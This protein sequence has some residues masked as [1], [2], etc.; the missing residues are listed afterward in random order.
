ML[1]ARPICI[2][3]VETTNLGER[4]HEAL[5]VGGHR[6]GQRAVDVEDDQ[7]HGGWSTN[8]PWMGGV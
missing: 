4:T 6:L 1:V 2:H 3:I 5:G 7:A 8:Q